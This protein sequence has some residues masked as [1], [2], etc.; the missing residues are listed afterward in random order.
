MSPESTKG[1][2]YTFIGHMGLHSLVCLFLQVSSVHMVQAIIDEFLD[3]I[4]S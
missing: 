2:S 1:Y 4:S 3:H